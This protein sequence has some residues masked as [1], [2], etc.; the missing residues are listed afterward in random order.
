MARSNYIFFFL[1]FIVM[2]DWNLKFL[3]TVHYTLYTVQCTLLTINYTLFTWRE[4]F[5]NHN[6]G[7]T[8]P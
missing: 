6:T 4:M 3:Y 8:G 1:Q 2:S 5:A 7:S